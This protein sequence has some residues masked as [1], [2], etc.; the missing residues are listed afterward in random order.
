MII[1]QNAKLD[2]GCKEVWANV[3]ITFSQEQGYKRVTDTACEKIIVTRTPSC[4]M[5]NEGISWQN[6][7]GG[8]CLVKTI[9]VHT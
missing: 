2:L 8:G 7:R 4:L 9:S 3:T 6:M 5:G 1:E